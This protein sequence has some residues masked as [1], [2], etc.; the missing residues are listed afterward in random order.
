MNMVKDRAVYLALSG[1]TMGF[2]GR[3]DCVAGCN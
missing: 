3:P 2:D 1:R